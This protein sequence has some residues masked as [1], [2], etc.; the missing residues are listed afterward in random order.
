MRQVYSAFTE[1]AWRLYRQTGQIRYAE[2]SFAAVEEGR[3]A[4]LRMLWA[5]SD[6]PKNLPQEYWLTMSALQKAEASRL[7]A[8]SEDDG[9][10]RRLRVR[11]AEMEAANGLELPTVLANDDPAGREFLQIT[12]KSLGPD[13]VFLA[14]Q[15]G[16]PQSW[17]WVVTRSGLEFLALA[18]E[19]DLKKD[20][21]AFVQALRHNSPQAGALGQHLYQRLFGEVSPD[22]LNRPTWIIDPDGSLFELPF[23]ALV[24]GASAE[25]SALQYVIERHAIRIVPGVSALLRSPPSEWNEMFVGVGDPIY[26]RADPRLERNKAAA[27]SSTGEAPGA[28]SATEIMELPRLLG[29]AREVDSC[30]KIWQMKGAETMVLKGS[31]ANKRELAQALA[32]R[33]SVVHVAAHMLFP[34]AGASGGMLALSLQAGSQVELLSDTET[35]GMRA[36]L[37]LVVLNGCSS[38]QAEVLPGAGLMGMSRAWLAAGAHAVILTR[39]PTSDQAGG[40]VFLSLYR[41]YFLHRASGPVSFGVLLRQAQMEELHAGGARAEPARWASYFCVETN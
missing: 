14:F 21:S 23:G 4:S 26:N 18:P 20:V 7:K 15:T 25:P 41:L 30:A 27:E 12:R 36:K 17:L 37:G 8:G 22:G 28:D 11:L 38:G 35:A 2:D 29:S 1:A 39:W 9:S 24:E 33:P 6:L 10:V 5:T 34:P 13:S 19:D 40:G 3:T 31:A 16:T 32:S